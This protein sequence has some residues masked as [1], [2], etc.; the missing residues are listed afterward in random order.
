M[1]QTTNIEWTDCTW[2]VARGCTKVD[3]DCK[4]CYMYRD[5][6]DGS[7]YNPREVV[8]TKTVFDLPYR[9]KEKKSKVWAGAPLIFTSSLT[10]WG[11]EAIDSYRHDIWETVLSNPHL[12]FQMLTK[13]IE[14]E[15][16]HPGTLLP[17]NWKDTYNDLWKN[18][19]LGTSV[20]HEKGFNRV[21]ALAGIEAKIK[22][23]SLEPLWGRLNLFPYLNVGVE[24][25][26]GKPGSVFDWVIIGGESGNE[27][28]QY[29]YRECKLEWIEELVEQC[30]KHNVPVF[31]KQLGTHLAKKMKLKDR[32][33][34]DIN[35]FPLH[36]RYRQFP[37]PY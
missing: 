34:R 23:L 2:N 20:G 5:S 12:Y 21:H 31:V 1:G 8:K 6:F 9:Y 33:G 17:A 30:V 22:F 24:L 35:E 15:L 11:H 37:K 10:D 26:T 36:L 13:R 29:R 14:R 18:V 16:S 19:W 4:F 7:R 25:R 28:G 32:H 27:T 3:G